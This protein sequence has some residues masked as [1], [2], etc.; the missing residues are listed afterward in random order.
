[1]FKAEAIAHFGGRRADLVRALEPDWSSSAVYLWGDIVP[2]AAARKLAERSGGKL[3]VV[4]DL[5]DTH[6]NII[7]AS[8]KKHQR[9]A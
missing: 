7:S 2:L 1:M 3:A 5:Y 9:T 8:N 4:E 6:G